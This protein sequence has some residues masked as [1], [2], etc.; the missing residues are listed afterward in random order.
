MPPGGTEVPQNCINLRQLYVGCSETS[1][2]SY[3]FEQ[4]AERFLVPPLDAIELRQVFVW[5]RV[6]RLAGDPFALLADVAQGF[7]V[8]GKI[9]NLFAPKA[10]SQIVLVSSGLLL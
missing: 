1:I 9:D 10:H 2:Q 6:S 7:V 3:R 5:Q 4:Q 8:E